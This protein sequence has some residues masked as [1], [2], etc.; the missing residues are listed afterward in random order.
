MTRTYNPVFEKP[1]YD[2]TAKFKE[3]CSMPRINTKII[4]CKLCMLHKNGVP[5][6]MHFQEFP[7]WQYW[8]SVFRS[9]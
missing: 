7:P 6:K 2:V 1:Q 5:G 8:Q 9:R 4:K 3:I